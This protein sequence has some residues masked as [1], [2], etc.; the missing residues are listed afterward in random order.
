MELKLR[1][2]RISKEWTQDYVAK[3]IGTTKT[4]VQM[5]E[6]GQ[7]KPS[8]HVLVK[9]LDLFQYDDPRKLFEAATPNCE[10]KPDGNPAKDSTNKE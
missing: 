2:E 7:R 8:Y 6:T 5:M 9:L 10:K 4:M 1:Q 3:K